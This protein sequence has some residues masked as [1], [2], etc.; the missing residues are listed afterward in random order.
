MRAAAAADT[1]HY[2]YYYDD[3]AR[4]RR[5]MS[6]PATV[7]VSLRGV[8]TVRGRCHTRVIAS[9][10]IG[11]YTF[12]SSLFQYRLFSFFL[13]AFDILYHYATSICAI[14]YYYYYYAV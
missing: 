14:D 10:A 5:Q 13:N 1:Q 6:E 11:L 2:Y 3:G 8:L 9:P 4:R 7:R 12:S